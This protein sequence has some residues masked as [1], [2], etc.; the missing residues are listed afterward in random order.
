M[1]AELWHRQASALPA[2]FI[3]PCWQPVYHSHSAVGPHLPNTSP[4]QRLLLE[5]WYYNQTP[6]NTGP[7]QAQS[8]TKTNIAVAFHFSTTVSSQFRSLPSL[9][10]KI[11][12]HNY[13]RQQEI[14][15]AN[16]PASQCALT[17]GHFRPCC[18]RV[19]CHLNALSIYYRSPTPPPPPCSHL[20]LLQFPMESTQRL[21][22]MQLKLVH[23]L[24]K[25]IWPLP[26]PS[27]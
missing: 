16:Q 1:C 14:V 21:A 15:T 13:P 3:H 23:Y 22:Y 25:L 9:R 17:N 4:K 18:R 19:K 10:L 26:S 20:L 11:Y 24:Y 8:P 5:T 6:R 12:W 7:E 27:Q 2:H